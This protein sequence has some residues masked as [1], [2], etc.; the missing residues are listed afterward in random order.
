MLVNDTGAIND[1]NV[2]LGIRKSYDT[3]LQRGLSKYQMKDYNGALLD[4]DEAIKLNPKYARAFLERGICY[5]TQQI[6]NMAIMEFTKA[7]EI[8]PDYGEAYYYRALSENY[9]GKK[10]E[11]CK[12]FKKA[13]DFKYE[14]AA[15]KMAEVCK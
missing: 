2:A 6:D 8:K 14:K 5:Y 1:C 7:I 3:Y 4:Y 12:D 10:D 11:S 15:A 9:S 13:V